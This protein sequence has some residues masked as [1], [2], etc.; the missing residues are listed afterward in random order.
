MADASENPYK[1]GFDFDPV[2]GIKENYGESFLGFDYRSS[3]NEFGVPSN[4]IGSNMLKNVS[5]RISTG[6]KTIEVSGFN[7]GQGGIGIHGMDMIPKQQFKEVERLKKLTGIDLTFH[8]PLVEVTGFQGKQGWSEQDRERVEREMIS[9]VR[10]A[11]ALDPKGNLVVT[12]HASNG[13]MEPETY[14][15]DDKGKRE[16]KSFWAINE[17]SGQ[18]Q[19]ISQETNYLKKE[20]KKDINPKDVIE[21]Q[22]TEQWLRQLQQI[23]FQ[24]RQ[25]ERII[26]ETF[27]DKEDNKKSE[28]LEIY[29]KFA[30]GEEHPVIK[31][32]E[33]ETKKW[34]NR[35]LSNITQ[36]DI[37]LRDAYLGF[38]NLFNNAYKTALKNENKE[39]IKKLEKFRDEIAPK[40]SQIEKDPSKVEILSDEVVRGINVLRGIETPKTIRPLREWAI[41]KASTSFSNTAFSAF[42][43]YKN[44]APIISIENPPAGDG[45]HTAEDLRD[46]VEQSRKMFTDK[47]MKEMGMSK[48]SAEEQA[49]KLIGVTWDVGHINM[50]RGKGYSEKQIIEQTKTIAPL[51]KHVHLSD[52]FGLSHTE[53]PM[54]MGNVPTKQMLDLIHQ[55]NKKVKKIAET[56]D[57][58]SQSGLNQKT[59]VRETLSSFGASAYGAGG[60]YWNQA[61]AI[62]PGYFSGHGNINPDFHH[63]LYGAGFSNLP[64][65]LGGQMA[66]RSRTSG[67]P[68]E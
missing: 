11:H 3:A 55:Y 6:I 51:V 23:T 53:L 1:K 37:Y 29:K 17:E 67:A 44:N 14:T 46:I 38:Q 15:I 4:P 18:F 42:K 26:E 43:E 7:I 64:L 40:I 8:A 12:F 58:L 5:D 56:G 10:R 39:D 50:L 20:E 62:T 16:V 32:L 63:S 19:P 24:A 66:G 48:H 34:L 28:L 9:T 27:K 47:A 13:L 35:E 68:I 36:G 61:S 45:L 41:E 65:E 2:Y 52:N 25:G 22:N 59:P 49:N 54:G 60:P 21:K 30:K 31:E 33:P 57:W